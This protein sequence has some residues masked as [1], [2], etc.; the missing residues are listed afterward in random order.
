MGIVREGCMGSVPYGTGT[1]P[2]VHENENPNPTLKTYNAQDFLFNYFNKRLFRGELR[3]CLITLQRRHTA[4]GFF[5][6]ARF[7]SHDG[8]DIADEIGLDPR[9][10]GAG[11]SDADNLSTLVHEMVHL[12]Q[13][14]HGKPSRGGYHNREF[15][16]KMRDIGLI[17]SDTGAPGGKSVGPRMSHFIAEGGPFETTCTELLNSGFVIPYAEIVTRNDEDRRGSKRRRG[18]AASKTSYVCPNC[19]DVRAWGKPGLRLACLNC[20]G[21]L[22]VNG[23]TGS[24]EEKWSPW[25]QPAD[26][27]GGLH[28]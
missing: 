27:T 8:T 10:W 26:Q 23:F 16:R 21:V 11:R 1:E 9:Y 28:S 24:E 7:R 15:A 5:A 20:S 22:E 14:H 19:P 6:G 25:Q 17:A 3:P 4:Y 2:E 12:W 18:R 13:H